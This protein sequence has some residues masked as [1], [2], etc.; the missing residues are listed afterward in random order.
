M[1][2]AGHWLLRLILVLGAGLAAPCASQQPAA[3]VKSD[4]ETVV[5]EAAGA[6][7]GLNQQN[8][9]AF[10]GKLRALKEKRG[11]SQEQFMAEAA[12][13]VRD[14]A[15]A[16]F[17]QKSEQLLT[18]ITSGGQDAGAGPPDCARLADLRAQMRAL[19][20]TQK[21]KWGYMF[22]KIEKELRK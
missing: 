5:D 18:R 16:G 1:P 20:E 11:W 17:D 14:E 2:R 3:C 13:F 10:Q 15:I 4:F 9:P 8:T 19:V 6:L 21:A 7:R 12:P 22:D